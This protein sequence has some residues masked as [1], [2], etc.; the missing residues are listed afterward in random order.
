MA[1]NHAGDF[2]V[3]IA[4]RFAVAC[5]GQREVENPWIEQQKLRVGLDFDFIIG[6]FLPRLVGAAFDGE[7]GNGLE[8]ARVSVQ[9]FRERRGDF[10]DGALDHSQKSE[11]YI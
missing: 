10:P 4:K 9:K 3:R 8:C 2:R 6:R 1:S 5:G 11:L 7:F